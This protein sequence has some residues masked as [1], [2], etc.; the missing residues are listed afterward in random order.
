MY[1]YNLAF[2]Y[3]RMGY[4]SAMAWIMFLIILTLTLVVLR[5]AKDRVYYAGR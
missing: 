1:L 4:A 2:R 5:I 3:L